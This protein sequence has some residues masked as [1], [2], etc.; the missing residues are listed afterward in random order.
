MSTIDLAELEREEIEEAFASR[1]VP[2]FHGRQVFHWIYARGV[3][4][5]S[6]MTNLS[7]ALRQTLASTFTISGPVVEHNAFEIFVALRRN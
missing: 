7:Q 4:D 2:K 6:Q 3:T 1:G 5:F